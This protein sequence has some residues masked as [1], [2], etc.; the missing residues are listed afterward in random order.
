[1][2]K[3]IKKLQSVIDPYKNKFD[4][5]I[6]ET[7]KKYGNEHSVIGIDVGESSIKVVQLATVNGEMTIVKSALV[8]VEGLPGNEEEVLA[9]LK[10]ALVGFETNGASIVSVVNCSQTCTRKIVTPHMPKKELTEAIKWE[11]KNAI[12]FSIDEALM[13]F[14]ILGEVVEKGVKKMIIAVAATPK[15]TVNRLLTLFSKAGVE[16]TTM[17]PISVSLQNLISVSKENQKL[18]IAVI[19]IGASITELNIYQQGRL[20]FSRKLPIAG[21]D[22]TKSMMSTLMSDKGKIELTFEEAE[23]IKKEIGIPV[24]EDNDLIDGKILPSQIL[25]LVRPCV[26]QLASEIERS[27]DFFREESHGEKVDKIILFGGGANLKGLTKSLYDEL[28]MEIIIGNSLEGIKIASKKQKK[29]SQ[30]ASQFDLAI[31]AVL[32]RSDKINLLPIEVKQKARRFVTSVSIQA[33]VVGI[34]MTMFLSFVGLNIQFGAQHKKLKALKLEQGTFNSASRIITFSN[35]L[36]IRFLKVNLTGK[37]FCVKLV[38]VLN[39][40]CI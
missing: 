8:P 25:S 22:I 23:K 12:P 14:D 19:E 4:S 40:G 33:V 27:F 32:N 7:R 31:G 10:T 34:V 29:N 13:G 37:M 5:F 3:N 21:G 15:E 39:H 9:S 36:L 26:E 28:E 30:A 35:G 1:M 16:I 2:Q 18:N 17:I 6:S 11:A 20:A 38:T 24:G